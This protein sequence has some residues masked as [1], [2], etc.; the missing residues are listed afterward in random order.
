MKED[1]LS[2]EKTRA[3]DILL[4]SLGFGEEAKIV[5]VSVTENRYVGKGAFPD[6]ES[7]EF[8]SDGNLSAAEIWAL[9]VLVPE[10]TVRSS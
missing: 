2:D 4:G 6:G 9:K 5:E 3:E 10:A 7:F 1:F 8:E